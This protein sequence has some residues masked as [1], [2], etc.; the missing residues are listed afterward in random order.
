MI[1]PGFDSAIFWIAVMIICVVIEACSLELTSIWFAVGA[2]AALIV[3]LCGGGLL[4]QLIAFTIA[5][6]ALLILVRPITRRLVRPITRRLLRPK[7]ARTN[8]DRIVG[9]TALVTEEIDNIHATGAIHILGQTWSAR[10][11]DNTVIA[12]GEIVRICSISGVKAM[13]ERTQNPERKER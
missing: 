11:I 2:L 1:P 13:V 8:A 3:L 10:S 4:P 7:G 12:A 5:A 9:E 6:A